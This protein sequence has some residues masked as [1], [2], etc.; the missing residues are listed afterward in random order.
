MEIFYSP[1][2]RIEPLIVVGRIILAGLFLL[3]MHLDP[4]EP[5]KYSDITYMLLTVYLG[6]SLLMVPLVWALASRLE[7]I[8]LVSHIIDVAMLTALAFFTGGTNSPVFAYFVFAISCATLRWQKSGTLWTA[9][10]F[11]CLFIGMGFFMEVIQN[12]RDFQ[13]NRFIIRCVYLAFIAILL[14]YLTAYEKGIRSELSKLHDWP[15]NINTSGSPQTLIREALAYAAE[16]TNVPRLLMIWEEQDEPLRHIAYLS[17]EEFQW[18]QLSPGIYE[19]LVAEHLGRSDFLCLN[20]ASSTAKVLQTSNAGFR[21]SLGS[22]LH[23]ELVAHYKIHRVIAVW[24]DGQEFQGRLLF[25]DKAGMNSDDLILSGLVGRQLKTLMDQLLMQQR[26]KKT[27]A[28][29]ER[30]RMARDL[31]DGVLQ[32]LTGNALQIEIIKRQLE[33]ETPT[34]QKGLAELQSVIINEQRNFRN[35]IQKLK[36]VAI[37]VDNR[38]SHMDRCLYNLAETLKLQWGLNVE[39]SVQPVNANLP[40]ALIDDIHY[41]LRESLINIARH[42]QASQVQAIIALEA[43]RLNINVS[44]DGKGFPFQGRYDLDGLKA[45]GHGPKT[46]MERIITLRGQLVI[47]SSAAGAG[48]EM[49]VPLSPENQTNYFTCADSAFEQE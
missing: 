38:K 5:A 27:A 21:Q 29:E 32:T 24:L 30:I 25:L 8:G 43:G 23:S 33:K 20:T 22:P 7:M 28:S 45:I 49:S 47:N 35:F 40:Q 4:Y 44:D 16:L 26:L 39:I 13:L 46:V 18:Q 12:N 10:A 14:I 36:P 48:L 1:R 19:P 31:H 15:G 37:A 9:L 41:L 6:Y 34:V 42:A 17:P 2:R 3:V 11:L